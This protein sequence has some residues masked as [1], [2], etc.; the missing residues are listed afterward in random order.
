MSQSKNL[1][2]LFKPLK[3]I[4][5][6]SYGQVIQIQLAYHPQAIKV[7]QA[8]FVYVCLMRILAR[9]QCTSPYLWS[10]QPWS[11]CL[12][13]PCFAYSRKDFE[14]GKGSGDKTLH[15]FRNSKGSPP[16]THLLQSFSSSV[17]AKA[18][19]RLARKNCTRQLS[20]LRTAEP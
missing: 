13:F 1:L 7:A 10:P 9:G 3:C 14:S 2:Y 6:R 19:R 8:A 4:W 5:F 11:S 18:R 17:M 12:Y 15:Q 16:H 20:P